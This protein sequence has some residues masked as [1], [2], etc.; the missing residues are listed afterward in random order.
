[1]YTAERTTTALD[2]RLAV[3]GVLGLLCALCIAVDSLLVDAFGNEAVLPNL[4]GVAAPPLGIAV[5]TGLY[6]RL[7]ADRP[8]R[9]LDAG[10][11]VSVAG[12][13]LVT[14]ID[15]TRTLVLSRLDD[16]VVDDLLAH[17]PTRP[18]FFA[19]ALVYIAGTLLFGAALIRRGYA[20]PAAWL[21][22]LTSVPSG[23]VV[24]LPDAAG[25]V[26]QT[27]AALGVAGLSRQLLRD[28][29]RGAVGATA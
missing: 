4:V 15:F 16:A 11:L 10:Y 1:M 23:L 29:R 26:A 20:V 24:L 21:Y 25:A 19:A 18:A 13:A 17:G 14:G 9:L 2:S 3:A 28:A 12:L 22:T 5:V 8:G 6:A 7:A 27:L